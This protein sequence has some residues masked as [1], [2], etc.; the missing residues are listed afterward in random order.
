MVASRNTDV[1]FICLLAA[2]GIPMIELG[3]QQ[4]KDQFRMA[5]T[6]PKAMKESAAL[7]QNL[8][9]TIVDNPQLN[10]DQ[11]KAKATVMLL[12]ELGKFPPETFAKESK[13][14]MANRITTQFL[15]TWYRYALSLKPADYLT[16]V[17]CPVL[18]INGT[19]DIQVES[20]TN[21]AGIK[22]A[23]QTAGNKNHEEVAL[24][25]LNHLFQQAKT[26]NITEYADIEETFNPVA[27]EKV[28]TWINGLRF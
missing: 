4:Q 3:L 27:L 16:K 18:S 22:A 12:Q 28:S 17:K 19:L 23:L 21:L 11:L 25:G 13:Q 24:P 8:F 10:S 15:S 7:L 14:D 26:G 6:K 1:K 9:K 5:G 20:V 2:P